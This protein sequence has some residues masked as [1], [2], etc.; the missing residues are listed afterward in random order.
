MLLFRRLDLFCNCRNQ[1]AGK[2]ADKTYGRNDKH[3]AFFGSLT[4]SSV[5]SCLAFHNIN[6]KRK[7]PSLPSPGSPL[8]DAI[9]NIGD[10]CGI[11]MTWPHFKKNFGKLS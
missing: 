10:F 8:M 5:V 9:R 11:P 4:I 1:T 7:A 3:S 2:N 6:A